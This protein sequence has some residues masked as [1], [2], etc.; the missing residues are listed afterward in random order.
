MSF[1]KGEP[2][3]SFCFVSIA[4]TFNSPAGGGRCRL[5]ASSTGAFTHISRW[6]PLRL[7]FVGVNI[8]ATFL[9]ARFLFGW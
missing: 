2:Y 7:L 6:E 1:L 8:R 9:V 3:P 5:K 4:T